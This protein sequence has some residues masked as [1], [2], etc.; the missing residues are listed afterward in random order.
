MLVQLGKCELINHVTSASVA[1]RF[2]SVR[3]LR[4]K[5]KSFFDLS[6][7]LLLVPAAHDAIDDDNDLGLGVSAAAM[8]S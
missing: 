7:F 8:T 4:D 5:T 2:A 6:F 3:H 1:E